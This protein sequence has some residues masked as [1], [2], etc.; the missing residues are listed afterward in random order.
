MGQACKWMARRGVRGGRGWPGQGSPWRRKG[1]VSWARKPVRGRLA[2]GRD[3]DHHLGLGHVEPQRAVHQVPARRAGW[4]SSCPTS[5][6]RSEWWM[7]CMRGVTTTRTSHLLQGQ[8]AGG[9]WSGG[10]GSTPAAAPL[11][12]SSAPRA[13]ADGGHLGRAVGDRKRHLARSGSAGRWR[14]RGRGPRGEPGGTARAPAAR[15]SSGAS[16]RACSRAAARRRPWPAAR[17]RGSSGSRPRCRASAHDT[18]GRSVAHCSSQRPRAAEMPPRA[19]LRAT[20]AR[21]GSGPAAQGAHAFEAANRATKAAAA[22]AAASPLTPAAGS[23]PSSCRRRRP[24]SAPGR[25]AGCARRA[26]TRPR[27]AGWW[28]RWCCR[29]AGCCGGPCSS[30]RPSAFWQYSLM[31]LLA[32]CIST[33]ARSSDGDAVALQQP[34]APPRSCCVVAILKT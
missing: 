21:P 22:V 2:I 33:M 27:G 7:P 26:R 6:R 4:R 34:L 20:R 28:R 18:K 31:R 12:R 11:Q 8:R 14:R 10:R 23:R 30:G 13:G 24:P 16:A 15:G 29:S 5:S 19:R 3:T 9:G 25:P 32:W 17:G 1:R